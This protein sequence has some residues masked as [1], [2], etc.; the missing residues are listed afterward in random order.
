MP[1]AILSDHFRR[2]AAHY[3]QVSAGTNISPRDGRPP[4]EAMLWDEIVNTRA[5][6]RQRAEQFGRGRDL[7]IKSAEPKPAWAHVYYLSFHDKKTSAGP[8]NGFYPVFLLSVDQRICWLSLCFAAGSVGVSARGGWSRKT[9]E[10]LQQ[11]ARQLASFIPG[12]RAWQ[13]GPVHLGANR[14]FMHEEPGSNKG[15]GR[16]YECG[17]IV[18]RSFDPSSP[19]PNLI[20]W[21][22][23]TFAFQD[24][25]VSQQA[26]LLAETSAAPEVVVSREQL[27]ALVTGQHA[28]ERFRGWVMS[29]H[30]EWGRMQDVTS[31]LGRGCDFEFP[32]VELKVDVKGCRGAIEDIQM[33]KNE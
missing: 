12:A 18:S 11:R 23:E 24:M 26:V 13:R 14:K 6:L 31:R 32:E 8:T 17:A 19:P 2:L 20:E 21:L 15:A 9:G 5:A 10:L 29:A 22:A 4:S 3:G 28:E 1:S 30:P 27:A 16:A 7:V 33:T 25:V